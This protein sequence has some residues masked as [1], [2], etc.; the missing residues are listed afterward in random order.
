[1]ADTLAVARRR[2]AGV[3]ALFVFPHFEPAE[4]MELAT[5][6][7]LMPAG[8][9]RHVIRWRALRLNLPLDQMADARQGLEQ[10]NA[11]LLEWLHQKIW[12]RQVRF[13]EEPTVLFDE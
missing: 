10:K 12:L 13:Y 9:T 4:V 2:H 8:I 1:G 7:E 11:L 5:G 3:T 6:G